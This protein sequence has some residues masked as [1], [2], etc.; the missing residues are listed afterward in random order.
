MKLPNRFSILVWACNI[1]LAGLI[2][3]LIAGIYYYSVLPGIIDADIDSAGVEK[4]TYRISHSLLSDNFVFE[5]VIDKEAEIDTSRYYFSSLRNL[6]L[7]PISDSLTLSAQKINRGLSSESS[8]LGGIVTKSVTVT[9][10]AVSLP[11][12]FAAPA[13]PLERERY[14]E[15]ARSNV[16][17]FLIVLLFAI[18]IFGLLR[19]FI[20]GLR[21]PVFFTRRNAIYLYCTAALTL[22][23]PFFIWIWSTFL[24]P[25]LFSDYRFEGASPVNF[26]PDISLALLFFGLILLVIAWCFDQGVKLQKEQELTI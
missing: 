9:E 8:R 19:Q 1:I 6:Y 17:Y 4:S 15:L 25:D 10:P 26:T 21:S 5:R 22:I 3:G 2:V 18:L 13:L 16:L 20:A 11:V 23:A 7:I 14:I 24:R 12:R